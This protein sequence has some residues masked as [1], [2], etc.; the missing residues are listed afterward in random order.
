MLNKFL[1]EIIRNKKYSQ[2]KMCGRH[3]LF[4]RK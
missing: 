1:Q 2:R 4:E 3:K